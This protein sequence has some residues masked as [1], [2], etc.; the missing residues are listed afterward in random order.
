MYLVQFDLSTLAATESLARK[1][2]PLLRH[3]DVLA[4]QGDLGAGKTTFARALL[5][6]LGVAGEVPSPTFTLVQIY[7]TP[8]FPVHHFDLY[9]L[10]D[11]SELDELGWDE[12][13]AAGVALIEWPERAA[14]R[15][16]M[17]CL[18]LHF[19]LDGRGNRQVRL[20]GSGSWN[21]RLKGFLI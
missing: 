16:T 19:T 6:A 13:L 9:R 7:D 5:Q 3:G 8:V 11:P 20:E 14:S 1:L 21:E 4:F 10:K 18:T 17:E 15:L 12:A 2:A